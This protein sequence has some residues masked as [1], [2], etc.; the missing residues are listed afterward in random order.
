M[1]KCSKKKK[2]LIPFNHK[3]NGVFSGMA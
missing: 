3:F 1:P 2:L